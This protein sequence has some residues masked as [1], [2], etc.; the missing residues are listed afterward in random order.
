[1][2]FCQHDFACLHRVDGFAD[3]LGIKAQPNTPITEKLSVRTRTIAPRLNPIPTGVLG[4]LD[5]LL[6]QALQ[7]MHDGK[8]PPILQPILWDAILILRCTGIRFSELA[9]LEASLQPDQQE[10]LDRDKYGRWWLCFKRP[11]TKVQ[12]KRL[13]P[14]QLESVIIGAIHRQCQRIMNIP[15]SSSERTLFRPLKGKLTYMDMRNALRKLAP[16]LLY[17]GQPYVITTSQFRH[18]LTLDA[19]EHGVFSPFTMYLGH[20]DNTSPY[21]LEHDLHI[22][23]QLPAADR[24]SQSTLRYYYHCHAEKLQNDLSR[25]RERLDKHLQNEKSLNTEQE[26]QDDGLQNPEQ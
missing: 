14:I 2:G 1:M 4:Q 10:C 6:M 20:T 15:G 12:I 8:E 17:E 11:N 25:W 9:H 23:G 21:L 7:V 3:V 24:P 16:H 5:V 13:I 26:Q 22:L 19:F 18:T